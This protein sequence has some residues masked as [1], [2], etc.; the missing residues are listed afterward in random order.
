[1]EQLEREA[2]AYSIHFRKAA[3]LEKFVVFRLIRSAGNPLAEQCREN[4]IHDKRSERL[5]R[6]RRGAFAWRRASW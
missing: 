5:R 4:R 1:V 3:L 2:D 6:E